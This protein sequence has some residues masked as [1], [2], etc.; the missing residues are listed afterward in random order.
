M[1]SK[2]LPIAIVTLAIISQ[3]V[4]CDQEETNKQLFVTSSFVFLGISLVS[5]GALAGAH[6]G[7]LKAQTNQLRRMGNKQHPHSLNL[8]QESDA[9]V[10]ENKKANILQQVFVE[11][12]I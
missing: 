8:N 11:N 6:Y 10:P 7:K 9:V 4:I 12:K 3:S 5:F 1:T 2:I